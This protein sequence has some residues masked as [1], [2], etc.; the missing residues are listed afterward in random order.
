VGALT[1]ATIRRWD[2]WRVFARTSDPDRFSPEGRLVPS[3]RVD[4]ESGAFAFEGLYPGPIELV[5][6]HPAFGE[7]E[8]RSTH[9]EGWG[10]PYLEIAI[11]RPDPARCVGLTLQRVDVPIRVAVVR[12]G[13]EV[14][15]EPDPR[16]GNRF[17]VC[18]L[19]GDAARLV[20]RDAAGVAVWTGDVELG[21][22][23]TIALG[24]PSIWGREPAGVDW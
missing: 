3:A 1:S 22:S 20:V 2:H 5:P 16:F 4:P 7:L 18:E 11:D 12:E 24:P 21:T 8:S 19:S 13:V 23:R 15:A 10:A 14:P 17:Q 9:V 6:F